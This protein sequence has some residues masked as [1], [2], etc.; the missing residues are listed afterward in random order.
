MCV[1]SNF[2]KGLLLTIAYYH[3]NLNVMTVELLKW[4]YICL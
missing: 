3:V 4:F 1:V 2:E